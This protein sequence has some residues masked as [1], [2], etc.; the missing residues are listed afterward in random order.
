MYIHPSPGYIG[1]DFDSNIDIL[2]IAQ[3]PG[4]PCN[5]I[6]D[7]AQYNKDLSFDERMKAYEAALKH[8]YMPV[9]IAQFL[10]IPWSRMAWTNV[11]KCPTLA[12][13]SVELDEYMLCS[14]YLRTQLSIIHPRVCVAM[15]N[16]AAKFFNSQ[17]LYGVTRSLDCYIVHMPHYSRFNHLAWMQ[18]LKDYVDVAKV[19]LV[20][21]KGIW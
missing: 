21:K 9:T 17:A 3:N 8:Y 14:P 7:R 13:R 20:K 16:L 10:N 11:V 1:K 4:K 15:G 19:A 12:N 6:F 18:M 5:N 2:F